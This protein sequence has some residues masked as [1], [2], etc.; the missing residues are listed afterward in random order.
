MS[1]ESVLKAEVKAQNGQASWPALILIGAGIVLLITNLLHISLMAYLWPGFFV[2][3]GFLMVWPA[4][5][6]TAASQSRLSFLAIPGAMLLA[7][8][9]LFFLMNLTDHFESMAYSWTLI[10]AAGAAGYAYLKRF[11]RSGAAGEKA[12]RFIRTMVLAFMGLATLFELLV[13]ESLG[14]WW[15]ILLIG[16]GV[17]LYLKNKRSENA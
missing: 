10:L 11:D 12:Q 16:V 13:F 1:E 7:M 6:S 17:Y 14:A 9:G 3:L 5:K 2:G 8:G 15:P 4:Y